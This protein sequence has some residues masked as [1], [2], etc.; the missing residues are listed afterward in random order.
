MSKRMILALVAAAT[1]CAAVGS[2][3]PKPAAKTCAATGTPM[4]EAKDSVR[5][6]STPNA[7]SRLYENGAFAADE[8]DA[9]GKPTRHVTGAC[10]AAQDLADA[11]AAVQ[12]ATWK[13]TTARV[14]CMAMSMNLTTYLVDGK[15][16]YTEQLCSGKTLD[17]DSAAALT[18]LKAILKAQT[19]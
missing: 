16:V 18:K 13:V 7:S 12:T 19:P 10:V 3:D 5:N 15:P 9:T 17:P 14:K 1:A 11:K 4:F 6:S 2:A 8:V